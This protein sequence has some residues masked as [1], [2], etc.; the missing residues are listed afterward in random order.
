M[1]TSIRVKI[2]AALT[3][4]ILLVSTL[5]GAGLY[6]VRLYQQQVRDVTWRVNVLPAAGKLSR[7]VA[8]LQ[9]IHGELRGIRA[10]RQSLSTTFGDGFRPVLETQFAHTLSDLK[11]GYE[12][13]RQLLEDRVQEI[14]IEESFAHEFST[15]D[16]IRWTIIELDAIVQQQG[17]STGNPGL[18]KVENLLVT[19]Q[20][21][22]DRLTV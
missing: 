6:A 2:W 16:S 20:N 19:M 18:E 7:H 13:Y 21:H 12:D 4:L 3:L 14:G 10:T 5:A 15:V 1:M 9:T 8:G 11:Q 17:W 22:A